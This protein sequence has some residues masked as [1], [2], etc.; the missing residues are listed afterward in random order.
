MSTH[1]RGH[2]GDGCVKCGH[3]EAEV[4]EI[5]TT[6]GGLSK[7]FDVQ[8]NSFKVVSCTNCGYSELY[9]DTG[10]AGSDLVDVFLG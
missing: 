2:D 6:G 8:T 10:S 3:T 5:S 9:R 1:G 7:M 4:G